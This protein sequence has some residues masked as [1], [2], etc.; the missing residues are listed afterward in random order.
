[1]W[2]DTVYLSLE[3][4]MRFV[5]EWVIFLSQ[6]ATVM[7]MLSALTMF[8]FMLTGQQRASARDDLCHKAGEGFVSC[9]PT[10]DTLLFFIIID[11]GLKKNVSLP[12]AR[13]EYM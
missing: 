12:Y 8:L 5:C 7:A 3:A 4:V 9:A 11:I 1:M 10:P 13:H 6:L 2:A